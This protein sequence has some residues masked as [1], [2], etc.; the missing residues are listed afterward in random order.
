MKGSL[1]VYVSNPEYTRVRI[2]CDKGEKSIP[3]QTHPNIDKRTF[4][5]TGVI[6]LKD[7]ERGFPVGTDVG[8]LKWRFQTT[9]D[10]QIP[11]SSVFA[12]VCTCLADEIQAE[13]GINMQ[14]LTSWTHRAVRL[15]A[16]VLG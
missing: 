4:A 13:G 16:C 5:K 9:D 1:T 6:G 12:D 14:S 7:K 11:L 2:H 10:A 3:Y 8:I 15:S